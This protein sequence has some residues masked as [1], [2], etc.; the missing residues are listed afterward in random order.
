MGKA[1]FW[2]MEQPKKKT[3]RI[4][5]SFE[6][7]AEYEDRIN[8]LRTPVQRLKDTVALISRVY[9]VPLDAKMKR[10]ITFPAH[11]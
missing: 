6:E 4:F 9:G 3:I 5:H 11:D 8:A 2:E 7:A 1:Y 10:V